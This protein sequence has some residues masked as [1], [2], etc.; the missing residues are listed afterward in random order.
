MYPDNH[1]YLLGT[2]LGGN[3]LL[4]YLLDHKVKNLKGLALLCPPFDVR[5]VIETMNIYYQKAFVK[6]YIDNTIMRHEQM[7][8]WWKTGIIDLDYLKQ[9]KDMK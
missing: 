1:L 4:R 5:Y 7:S 3:Y 2:S 9:S 6:Y 8:F